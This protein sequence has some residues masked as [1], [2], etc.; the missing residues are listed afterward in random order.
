MS[1]TPIA[2]IATHTQSPVRPV[3]IGKNIWSVDAP[4]LEI[5]ATSSV[6]NDTNAE[7]TP[8]LMLA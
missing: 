1:T 6:N 7:D 8:T 5:I 4:N 3:I 2:T